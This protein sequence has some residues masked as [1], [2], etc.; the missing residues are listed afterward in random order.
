METSASLRPRWP[1]NAMAK[2]NPQ[3]ASNRGFWYVFAD[4]VGTVLLE[5]GEPCVRG[6]YGPLGTEL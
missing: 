5:G 1:G 4:K 2:Q 3:E 6:N